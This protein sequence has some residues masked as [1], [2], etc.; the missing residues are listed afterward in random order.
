[1][2]LFFPKKIHRFSVISWEKRFSFFLHL[3]H[4]SSFF[5]TGQRKAISCWKI[6]RKSHML[7][8]LADEWWISLRLWWFFLM[9]VS[10]GRVRRLFSL[11][12]GRLWFLG[13][14]A[15]KIISLILYI[16]EKFSIGNNSNSSPLWFLMIIVKSYHGA[17]KLP[18]EINYNVFGF[19]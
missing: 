2:N 3:F 7:G 13:I 1:M 18:P 5:K 19:N 15:F 9:K 6:L 12:S 16:V 14:Y 8:G 4:S 11:S 17:A 10:E